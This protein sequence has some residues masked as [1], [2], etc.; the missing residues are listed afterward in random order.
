MRPLEKHLLTC[1][2]VVGWISVFIMA[3]LLYFLIRLAGYKVRNVRQIRKHCRMNFKAHKGPWIICANHFTLIDSMIIIYAM[4]PFYHYLLN[5]RMLPWNLPERANF[6]KNAFLTILTYLTKCIP[7]SRGGDS[8][9]TKSVLKKCIYLLGKNQPVFIFPE[10]GR[11]RIGRVDI[12]NFSY[13]VGYLIKNCKDV[14]VMC[15]Y[16][17][18]D[19]QENYSNLPRWGERFTAISEVLKPEHDGL[20]GLRAQRSYA[21]QVIKRLSEMEASYFESRG[22]KSRAYHETTHEQKNSQ[23]ALQQV[24]HHP[25]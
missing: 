20:S 1:Q 22:Q 3:P 8:M 7:V 4:A 19:H 12:G 17:R 5:Y 24:H 13:G 23:S 9:D 10:G 21:E 11:T 15:I 16:L 2:Y 25:R 14:K 18:G 6:R